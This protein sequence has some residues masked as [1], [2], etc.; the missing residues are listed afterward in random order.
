LRFAIPI[1]AKKSGRNQ[2]SNGKD[3]YDGDPH[4][5]G[6]NSTRGR[7]ALAIGNLINRDPQYVGRFEHTLQKLTDE[8]SEAV[9]TCIAFTLRAIAVRD[10]VY[11][12][13]LF[14]QCCIHSPTLRYIQYGSDLIRVGLRECILIYSVHTLNNFSEARTTKQSKQVLDL[15]VSRR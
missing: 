7:A 13:N 12:L 15:P 3:Y 10:Y 1:L 14:E 2:T 9:L 8:M 4:F 11:A 6:I 5:H